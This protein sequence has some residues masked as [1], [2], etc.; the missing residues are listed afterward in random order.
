MHSYV[1]TSYKLSELEL[2]NTIDVSRDKRLF[3]HFLLVDVCSL[4]SLTMSKEHRDIIVMPD[5][6]CSVITNH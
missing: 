3:S 1:Q 4:Q 2:R 6:S 5:E